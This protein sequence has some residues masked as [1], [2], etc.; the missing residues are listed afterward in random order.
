M[1]Y[2]YNKIFISISAEERAECSS[3]FYKFSIGDNENFQQMSNNLTF[4][5]FKHS[6]DSDVFQI[7]IFPFYLN[8][9]H[10]Y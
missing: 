3:K 1:K 4:I 6:I 5:L 10:K 8:L 7:K 9:I 2:L